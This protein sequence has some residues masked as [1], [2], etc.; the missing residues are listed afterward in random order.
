[1]D[2]CIWGI[3]GAKNQKT[4]VLIYFYLFNLYLE[5]KIIRVSSNYVL[6]WET[7]DGDGRTVYLKIEFVVKGLFVCG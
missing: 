4:E 5:D 3:I 2:V 6:V 7:K 1:M